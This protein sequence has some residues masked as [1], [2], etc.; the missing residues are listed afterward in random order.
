MPTALCQSMPDR[1]TSGGHTDSPSYPR[2]A[3]GVSTAQANSRCYPVPFVR[4]SQSGKD[5]ST[6]KS[7]E[8]LSH[9]CPY[10]TRSGEVRWRST[11]HMGTS[12]YVNLNAESRYLLC[13]ESRYLFCAFMLACTDQSGVSCTWLSKH[14][15]PSSSISCVIVHGLV[16]SGFDLSLA[17]CAHKRL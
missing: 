17:I 6:S 14:S 10:V 15:T 4:F 7:C 13:A 12:G 3:D 9:R 11:S 2:P 16:C 5:T 8:Q 1:Q